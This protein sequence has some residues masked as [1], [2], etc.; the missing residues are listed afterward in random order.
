MSS[1]KL[2]NILLHVLCTALIVVVP[3]FVMPLKEKN[4]DFMQWHTIAFTL[5]QTGGFYFNA[6]VLY[7]ALLVKRRVAAYVFAVILCSIAFALIHGLL[8][9]TMTDQPTHNVTAGI[10]VKIFIGLFVLG[11]STS[12]RFMVDVAKQ[13][14]Q[15]QEHMAMELSFLRSQVSPHFM[16]NALNSMV[17]LARKK[18]DQLEPALLKMSGL[19]HYM[20]YD[21]DEE[22]V[23]LQK[24]VDYIR[25][26]ID[27]QTMRFGDTVKILFMVQ[28][29]NYMHTIEPMLLIPLIEN[30][31]KHGVNVPDAPEINIQLVAGQKEVMLMVTNKTL[32]HTQSADK[33]KGIGLN[34]LQRR[35]KLLY[36]GKHHLVAEKQ[37]QWYHAS[38]KICT[39]DQVPGGR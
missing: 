8:Y 19:M 31:F 37:G 15:Q 30:A 29:G 7:P 12:Y 23:S 32:N 33:T 1:K 28:P 27:L 35:L 24:E 6:Y 26:Y 9:Y 36:P 5:L 20:L 22:K 2:V 38:L 13:Q 18:S 16:F 3:I 17:S 25:S 14:R 21:S 11:T 34:N 10:I 4:P 39:H